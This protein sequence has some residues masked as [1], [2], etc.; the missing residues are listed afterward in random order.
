MKLSDGVRFIKGVGEKKAQLFSRLGIKTV[1]DLLYHLPRDTEDRTVIKNICD[2]MDGE[3]VCVKATLVQ[4][5]KSFRGNGGI[6]ICQ[7]VF[8][9]GS[10]MLKVTWFNS[11]YIAKALERGKEYIIFGKAGFKTN[12]FEMINPVLEK[13]GE[14][15][16]KT[17]KILPVYPLTAGL[18]QNGI[19]DAMRFVFENLDEKPKETIPADILEKYGFMPV[20]EALK[21]IHFPTS[22]EDFF[23]AKTRLYFEEMLVMQTGILKAKDIRKACCATPVTN[24][25]CVKD[26]AASLPFELTGAQKRVINE[27]CADLKKRIPM[28][29]LVQGDVGSGKT[30]V[31]AAAV[32]AAVKSGFQAALMAPTEILANQ[33]YNTFSRVFAPFGIKAVLLTGGQSAKEKEKNLELIKSGEANFVVGT[34]AVI[35][36]NVEFKNLVLSITDEQHRFGVRQRAF[37]AEKG[38]NV[39]NLVMTATPI[40]RTLSLILYG[41]LDI[42]VIDELPPG[43]KKIKTI[44]AGEN[45]RNRVYAFVR[46]NIAEGGQAYIVCPLVEES[47]ALEAK[48]ASEYA[49]KLKKDVFFDL[50]VEVL[51]GRLNAKEK[52]EIMSRF[53]KGET[54]ILVSTTVIEVGV[55][56][57]NANIMIIEN[58]ERFGLSQLHQ[59][60]GRVGR[61]GEEAFCIL[62]CASKGEIAKERVKIM[63][64]TRD[65][66]KIAE[67]DL[68]L[69]GPGEFFGVRQHGLPELKIADL[70]SDMELL[71]TARDAAAEITNKDPDLKNKENAALKQIVLKKFESYGGKSVLN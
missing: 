55:D 69:R 38:L 32:F 66:F 65:G 50:K 39:H 11:P 24:V 6:R 67:Y 70:S 61:G 1:Y 53:S 57:P 62:F 52:D 12:Y 4:G 20:W 47:E 68:K 13:E 41:D 7:T 9:D 49:E 59:L 22:S 31:A 26:F 27:V 33:H 45:L 35:S 29:R 21:A 46:K 10:G 30:M 8:G 48:A 63:C 14:G 19:R 3:T 15:G 2:L 23:S 56:V 43:R 64:E 17:G 16:E 40:P 25:S 42:S 28:N 71:K 51:H 60:R 34:H 54:D 58:A 36:E 5:I 44:A 18:S 37:L